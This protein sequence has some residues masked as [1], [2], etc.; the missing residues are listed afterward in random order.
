MKSTDVIKRLESEG[1]QQVGG[2]G[3]HRKFK[4]QHHPQHVVVPH[5]RQDI[6]IGTLRNIYRQAGWDWKR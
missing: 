6:S 5:P 2:K 1:W 4:H 3:D